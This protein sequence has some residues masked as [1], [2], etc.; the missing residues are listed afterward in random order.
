[1]TTDEKNDLL[2][3]HI[4]MIEKLAK[5]VAF[6]TF[7]Q[8]DTEDLVNVGAIAF[9]NHCENYD[10]AK[11]K[12]WT[13]MYR[14]VLGAMKDWLRNTLDPMTR[15]QRQ[16]VRLYYHDPFVMKTLSES[17]QRQLNALLD[18]HEMESLS[19]T[20]DNGKPVFQPVTPEC[21]LRLELRDSVNWKMKCLSQKERIVFLLYYGEEI[22]LIEI[23]KLIGL[24]ESRCSQILSEAKKK[25]HIHNENKQCNRR[26]Y[27]NRQR[28]A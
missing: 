21:V 1:M 15:S 26:P 23:G 3:E 28:N 7:G 4:G 8:V 24:S 11:G 18:F 27:V 6:R 14:R 19:K 25:L 5:S 2:L 17:Q 12:F 10:A 13:W 22:P 9:L 20:F 16:M